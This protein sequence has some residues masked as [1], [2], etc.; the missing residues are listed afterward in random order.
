M[1][2]KIMVPCPGC[3]MAKICETA[4]GDGVYKNL[5]DVEDYEVLK[6]MSDKELLCNHC[7]ATF[8]LRVHPIAMVELIREGGDP[9][10]E[11]QDP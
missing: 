9:N 10:G 5:F 8:V 6:D 7:Y 2:D 1:S 11:Y 4:E 3:G